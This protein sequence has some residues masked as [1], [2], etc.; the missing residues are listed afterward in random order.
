[1]IWY[2]YKYV[3]FSGAKLTKGNL[4]TYF[5]R[6]SFRQKHS[7]D[8]KEE[9]F[10]FL[11]YRRR[12]SMNAGEKSKNRPL[13]LIFR[14]SIV[15]GPTQRPKRRD[16][17]NDWINEAYYENNPATMIRVNRLYSKV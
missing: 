12:E 11:S 1:V 2:N 17:E 14:R 13:P 16:H 4:E 5:S 9:Y 8:K 15:A 3:T 6:R 7:E 10:R